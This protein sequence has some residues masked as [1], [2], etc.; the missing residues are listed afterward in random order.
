[1]INLFFSNYDKMSSL[2]KSILSSKFYTAEHLGISPNVIELA[3]GEYKALWWDDRSFERY[4]IEEVGKYINDMSV[5][6]FVGLRDVNGNVYSNVFDE[7]EWNG[8]QYKCDDFEKPVS[9][10]VIMRIKVDIKD[11]LENDLLQLKI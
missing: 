7:F 6:M 1:M 10:V 8:I 4:S 5:E 2:I 11:K 3:P 9:L